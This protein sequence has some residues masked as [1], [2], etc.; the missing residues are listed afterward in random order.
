MQLIVGAQATIREYQ[1]G[2]FPP[3]RVPW[4]Y[5]RLDAFPAD[6][7]ARAAAAAARAGGGGGAAVVATGVDVAGVDKPVARGLVH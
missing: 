7:P 6:H 3:K 2:A 5:K 4:D 1:S